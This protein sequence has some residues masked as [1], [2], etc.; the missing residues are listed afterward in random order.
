MSPAA[1]V[2]PLRTAPLD[3][4]G[5]DSWLH[6]LARRNGLSTERLL[7]ALT[8]PRPANQ[9]ALITGQEPDQLRKLEA[10]AALEPGQLDSMVL[11][12]D[13][14]PGVTRT[15][16]PRYCPPCLQARGGRFRLQWWSPWTFACTEHRVLLADQCPTCRTRPC[17]HMPVPARPG[18]CAA[19]LSERH[20]CITDLATVPATELTTHSPLLD[21]QDWIDTITSGRAARTAAEVFNDLEFLANWLQRTLNELDTAD[22][23]P[24]VAKAWDD[25]PT[26]SPDVSRSAW[27]TLSA[28][29]TA[30][31]TREVRDLLG[32]DDQHAIHRLRVLGRRNAETLSARPRTMDPGH[33]AKLSATMHNRLLRAADPD[34]DPTSRIRFRSCTAAARLPRTDEPAARARWVPQVLWPD[35]TLRLL[36]EGTHPELFRAVASA[37]VLLVGQ[38]AHTIQATTQHLHSHLQ[39]YLLGHTLQN[40]L[41]AGNPQPLEAF[42]RIADYLDNEGSPIDYQRRRA[43]VTADILTEDDWMRICYRTGTS[44]GEHG[45]KAAPTPRFRRAQR[46][47]VQL[48]TGD[49]LS[50]PA[51]PLTWANPGQRARYYQSVE[52]FPPEQ[53]KALRDHGQASLRALGIREPLTWSPPEHLGQDLH[54]PGPRL[55]DIDLKAV[56][57]LVHVQGQS[58]VQA[59]T[60][61]GT[62][63]THIRFALDLIEPKRPRRQPSSRGSTW[64]HR[65]RART[66]LTQ[67]FFQREYAEAGK[68]AGKIAEELDM[69]RNIVV[70][71]ARK[72][73][74]TLRRSP[75][76]V[77]IDAD[78]LQEQYV[79]HRRSTLSLAEE[80]GTEDMTILRRLRQLD[81]PIRPSGVHSSHVM[82]AELPADTPADIKK[83]VQATRYGW[84]R[85]ARFQAAMGYPNLAA[86]G[87]A[88]GIVPS[89]L[90]IQLQQLEAAIGA[91]LFHRSDK[92]PSGKP[93]TPTARGGELLAVLARPE[94]QALAPPGEF[95]LHRTTLKWAANRKPSRRSN[96]TPLPLVPRFSVGKLRITRPLLALLHHVVNHDDQ[97]F[98]GWELIEQ[99]GMDAGTVY[100]QL[101]R[102]TRAGWL[103]SRPEDE[104]AWLAGAPPGRG[105]GRRRTYYALTEEGRAAAEYEL[106]QRATKITSPSRW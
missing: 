90:V 102:L 78:W 67:E 89:A 14:F 30:V 69:P 72:A 45:P 104:A 83:S 17:L 42:C 73:G 87:K 34:L 101:A 50:N 97:E 6:A 80:I 77:D 28:P 55:S 8:L 2:L 32:E 62:N 76:P 43:L 9:F 74:L 65:E 61:L 70:E 86:A 59:A 5:I 1:R 4:E 52:S 54:L 23:D 71:F 99:T 66:L 12:A 39:R 16:T 88:L 96:S 46:Y 94:I 22:L 84:L 21:T 53:R 48:L 36:P 105:P 27:R 56:H 64:K 40:M 93:M 41:Q 82:I 18:L 81:I 7:T 25:G 47:L 91:P 15:R 98:Y 51:N 37:I 106:R 100:P 92:H 13:L 68:N 44:P 85:L 10:L 3:G 24:V 63:H 57:R 49:D 103:T 19:R 11:P 58:V 20:R 95:A 38:P 26:A 75:R 79:N 33:F 35:W 29:V 31:I 60:T